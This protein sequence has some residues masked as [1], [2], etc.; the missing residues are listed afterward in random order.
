MYA[1]SRLR[2]GGRQW[3]DHPRI[4]DEGMPWNT[5]FTRCVYT[6]PPCNT[7]EVHLLF[8]LQT[9]NLALIKKKYTEINSL[10]HVLV[11]KR[12]NALKFIFS[13]Q[14]CGLLFPHRVSITCTVNVVHQGSHPKNRTSAEQHTFCTA[15]EISTIIIPPSHVIEWID[16]CFTENLTHFHG[17][18][19]YDLLKLVW[20]WTRICDHSNVWLGK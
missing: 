4:P 8:M 20:Y 12:E 16:N 19:I 15:A 11:N 7:L 13:P 1:G 5:S 14:R 9:I 2:G 6:I 17:Y 18:E 10:Q 3:E